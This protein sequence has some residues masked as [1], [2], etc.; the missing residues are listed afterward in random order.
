MDHPYTELEKTRLWAAVE[1]AIKDLVSNNDLVESTARA[2]IVGYLCQKLINERQG[3]VEGMSVRSETITSD[4]HNQMEWNESYFKYCNFEEFSEY[5]FVSSDFHAC[6]FKKIDWY[7]N[8]FSGCNFI[9]CSFVDCTF[10]GTSFPECRFIDCE[11]VNCK[12]IQDNLGGECDFS[13]SWAHGCSIENS[14]GFR[15]ENSS[16]IPCVRFWRAVRAAE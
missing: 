9:N 10:A 2:Y 4:N 16:D 3:V 11:L 1:S 6:S 8:L 12:F 15:P 14:P 13:N 5:G 7:W